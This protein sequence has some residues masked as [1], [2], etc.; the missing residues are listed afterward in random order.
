MTS[1]ID[2][3][4]LTALIER[5]IVEKSILRIIFTPTASVNLP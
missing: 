1:A 4:Q 2:A 5:C 3:I